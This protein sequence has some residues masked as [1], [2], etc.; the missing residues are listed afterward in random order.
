[1]TSSAF[2]IV[3][4]SRSQ[5]SLA[6]VL[7]ILSAVAVGI[8]AELRWAGTL[9]YCL[10]AV[11]LGFAGALLG[12]NVALCIWRW[13]AGRPQCVFSSDTG[14]S[15]TLGLREEIII[16]RH[17]NC[18]VVISSDSVSAQHCRLFRCGR[19]WYVE[20]LNSTNGTY[21]DGKRI[22]T[23]QLKMGSKIAVAEQELTVG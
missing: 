17:S 5:V 3:R 14:V 22:E 20:D 1:M 11:S 10:A 18:D 21:I 16:G 7:L 9:F 8:G 2:P 6:G 13:L 23:S 12:T 15:F 19:D 4:G